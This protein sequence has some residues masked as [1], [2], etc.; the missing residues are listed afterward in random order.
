MKTPDWLIRTELMI[1]KESLKK[2]SK[3]H[4]LVAGLGGVGGYAGGDQCAAGSGR[5]SDCR[6]GSLAGGRRRLTA[7][8]YAK[9]R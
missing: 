9:L 6:V 2:L 3:A 4:V 8:D 7:L 1:G 5:G